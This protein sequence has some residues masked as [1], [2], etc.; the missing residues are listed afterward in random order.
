MLANARQPRHTDPMPTDA[1][2]N[3]RP[4]RSGLKVL[5]VGLL[6]ILL[7]LPVM[8]VLGSGPAF[9]LHRDGTLSFHTYK[10]MYEPLVTWVELHPPAE[11]PFYWWRELWSEKHPPRHPLPNP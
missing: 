3:P 6:G 11:K 5:A 4:T 1:Q 2:S 8:Y 9:R 7:G 10:A